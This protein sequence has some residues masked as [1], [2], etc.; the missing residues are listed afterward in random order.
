[1][2]SEFFVS[3]NVVFGRDAA[4]KLPEILK[5]YKA[6]NVMVV[7]DAGGLVGAEGAVGFAHEGKE[8]TIVEMKSTIAEEV[9]SF[10]RGGLMPEVEK[11]AKCLVNTKVKEI[12]PEGVLC[13]QD[14]KEI[15]VEADSVVC[16]LGFA[17]PYDKVDALTDI[18]DEYYIIGDCKKVGKIYDAMNT[19]YYSALLV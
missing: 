8:C 14:G 3:S 6:K 7:Y 11:A 1:M 15:L 13:E 18:V 12:V 16:A 19:A 17:S 5:E 10:Y 2:A 9:N 4:K